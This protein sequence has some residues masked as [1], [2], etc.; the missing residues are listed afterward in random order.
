MS[1]DKKTASARVPEEDLE[2]VRDALGDED[3]DG[4]MSG[5]IRNTFSLYREDSIYR[6]F[7][8]E[9]IR[10]E[11]VSLVEYI[12]Q[13]EEYSLPDDLKEDAKTGV[14]DLVAGVQ[15]SS[16]SQAVRGG[17]RIK[18]VNEQMGKDAVEYLAGIPES[19]WQD[20]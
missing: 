6:E 3:I 10:E 20:K 7:M 16:F 4:N 8:N 2:W 15:N 1:H 18:S 5:L 11:S 9:N 13:M 12:A 14:Q 17:E 19:Y